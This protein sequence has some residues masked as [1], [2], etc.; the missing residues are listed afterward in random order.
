MSADDE[1]VSY[2]RCKLNNVPVVYTMWSNLRKDGSM[3]TGQVSP[4]VN[5]WSGLGHDVADIDGSVI[6]WCRCQLGLVG[7][8]A[9]CVWLVL[10][11]WFWIAVD[12]R[13]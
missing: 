9:S 5:P 3:A 4:L 12:S 6:G 8:D 10:L 11:S 1:D 2:L 7:V 13:C